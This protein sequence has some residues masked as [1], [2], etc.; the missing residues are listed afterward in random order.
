[1]TIQEMKE[2]YAICGLVCSLC[3]YNTNCSGCRDK[4]ENCEIKAC[5]IDKGLKYCFECEEYPCDKDMHKNLRLRAF[6]T[7][8]RTE[9]LDQLAEYLLTNYNR[10]IVYHRADNLVGDYDRCRTMEEII[11]L[12]KNGKP[13]PYDV[14]PVYESKQFLLRLVSQEDAADLLTCYSNPE[15][16]KI[17]NADT[18]TSDF[19]YSS[20]HEMKACIDEWL[21]AYNQ[22][23]YVRLSIID[24]QNQKAV[25]T[26]EIFASDKYQGLGIL[27]IDIHPQYE[28]KE[29]LGVLLRVADS[30]F[31]DFGCHSIVSKAIPDAKER[32]LA[33]TKQGYTFYPANSEWDRKEYYIKR[34][35]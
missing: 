2:S 3:S 34:R 4:C 18:C 26:V 13:N 15:A 14:P 5:C 28:D 22:R 25:G 7:V 17:F 27:R 1:M 32:I 10:G 29:H 16:Q 21:D 35:P 8:A 6:N 20:L 12:L 23:Q 19:C 9:G 24:R 33:L 30:F 31:H 11:D